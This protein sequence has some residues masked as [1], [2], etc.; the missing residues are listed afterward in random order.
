MLKKVN[1]I[2][3]GGGMAFTFLKAQGREV[4]KSLCETEKL[5]FAAEMLSRAAEL[6]VNVGHLWRVIHG[7]R[8]SMRLMAELKK[9]GIEVKGAAR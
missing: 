8:S 4:G 2:V 6:G 5:D 1:S 3:I 9:R 7:E